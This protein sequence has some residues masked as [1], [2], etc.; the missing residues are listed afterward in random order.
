[1]H[2]V[3]LCAL[4]RVKNKAFEEAKE[5]NKGKKKKKEKIKKRIHIEDNIHTYNRDT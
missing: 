2:L 3:F 4:T 1:M 5:K